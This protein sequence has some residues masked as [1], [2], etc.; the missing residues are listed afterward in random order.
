MKAFVCDACGMAITNPYEVKMREFYVRCEFELSGVFPCNVRTFKHKIHLCDDCYHALHEIG[1]KTAMPGGGSMKCKY[2]GS[3][4]WEGRCVGTREV[5]PCKGYE[6][7]KSYCP[8]CQTN[9]DR[10]RALSDEDLAE[11]FEQTVSQRD[12]YLLKKLQEAGID[13]EL[14]E[15]P[16]ATKKKHLDW[17][18]QPA[19]GEQHG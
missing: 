9:A 16:E 10:I 3:G 6:K 11:L 4:V 12:H 14:Y 18:R 15:I 2:E 8:D 17:L 7:C 5:D 19:G 1:K 13:A